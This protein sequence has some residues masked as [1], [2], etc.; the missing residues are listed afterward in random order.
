MR[1][2]F[3]SFKNFTG[4]C[5]DVSWWAGIAA[6][7]G[8][9][10]YNYF[11][12]DVTHLSHA[13]GGSAAIY[14]IMRVF[15]YRR[16]LKR[17]YKAHQYIHSTAHSFR[18]TLSDE[19][20]HA[21]R[22]SEE[23]IDA[24]TDQ[25]FEESSISALN[26]LLQVVVDNTAYAFREMTNRECTAVLL[27]PEVDAKDGLRFKSMIY[28]SGT[29]RNRKASTKPHTSKFIR[30]VFDSTGVVLADDFGELKSKGEYD[31]IRNPEKPFE[32]YRSAILCHFKVQHKPWGILAVDSPSKN[33]FIL[34]YGEIICAFADLCGLSFV[35]S[36]HGDLGNVIYDHKTT[37]SQD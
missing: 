15:A 25:E 33:A 4:F 11:N 6:A 26:A 2:P 37:K 20:D 19:L 9:F 36:K 29:A 30:K 18:D 28:S 10:I 7:C 5:K 23:A 22:A 24:V 12:K 27:M 8:L 34:D 16:K 35:L 13:I 14:M 32:W 17:V 1:Y 21:D 31:V 3:D